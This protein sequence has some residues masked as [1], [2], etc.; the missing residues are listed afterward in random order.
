MGW[1]TSVVTPPDGNMTDYMNGLGRLMARDDR[2]LYPTHGGPIENPKPFLEAYLAHRLERE[3]QIVECLRIGIST[4]PAIVAR[5]YADVDKRLHPA[6]ARY[7][8]SASDQVGSKKG[9]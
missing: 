3:A 2:T 4:I 5:L 9:A 7:G 8:G 6:A 1:S